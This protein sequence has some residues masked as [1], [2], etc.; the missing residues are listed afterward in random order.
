MIV[1]GLGKYR[2][3]DKRLQMVD[4]PGGIKV[5]NDSYNANPASMAA[6][7]RTVSEFGDRGC[8]KV[9][10]LG[11]MLELGA[12]AAGSHRQVGDLVAE[13]G[14]DYL[15]VTGSYAGEVI[16]AACKAGMKKNRVRLGESTEMLAHWLAGLINEK[17]LQTGDWLLIKGSRGIRMERVLDLLGE[18]LQ[19]KQ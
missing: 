3:G 1:S 13:L 18:L 16:E 5:L 8:R 9:A 10:V 12:A 14:F 7:L 15:A 4:L 6:A 11:D 2:S 19:E 17:K